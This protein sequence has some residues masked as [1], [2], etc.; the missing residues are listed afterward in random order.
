MWIIHL[1]EWDWSTVTGKDQIS[2]S[3]LIFPTGAVEPGDIVL[4]SQRGTC[5]AIYNNFNLFFGVTQQL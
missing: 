4:L 3:Y 5:N 2:H 1:L